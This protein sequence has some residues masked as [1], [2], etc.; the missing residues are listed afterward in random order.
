MSKLSNRYWLETDDFLNSSEKNTGKIDKSI[1]PIVFLY[2]NSP[3]GT[4][5]PTLSR[6]EI[7]QQ[8]ITF[9]KKPTQI[10]KTLYRDSFVT[11]REGFKMKIRIK[12]SIVV[13][14]EPSFTQ[15]SRSS[16]IVF[17]CINNFNY[18]PPLKDSKNHGT[19]Y[20]DANLNTKID[21][22]VNRVF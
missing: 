13:D 7:F 8:K 14:P 10:H 22:S 9:C 16:P 17:D 18:F 19:V 15:T 5:N 12:N 4:N 11:Y 2:A 6:M 20:S 1:L 3:L 21:Y